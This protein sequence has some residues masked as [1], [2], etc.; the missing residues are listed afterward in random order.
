MA[1]KG[2]PPKV[3]VLGGGYYHVVVRGHKFLFRSVLE[4]QGAYSD[5]EAY[6]TAL[7]LVRKAAGV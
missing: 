2:R 7:A 4:L 5:E 1:V 6:T 3:E